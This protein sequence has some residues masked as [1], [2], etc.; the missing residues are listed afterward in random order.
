MDT[1]VAAIVLLADPWVI[2]VILL[3]AALGLFVGA[4]PGLTAAMAVALLVPVTLYM[5]PVPALAMIATLSCMAI[6][7]GDIPGCLLRIPGTLASAAYAEEAYAMT[8]K[9]HA[10]TALGASVVFAAIGG[11]LG[12]VVLVTVAPELAR[13]ALRFSSFEYFWLV[14]LGLSC[15]V[16]VGSQ[17]TTKS[18]LS[19]MLG[20]TV[21]M[22]GLNNPAAFPRLTFG[23]VDLL[24]GVELIAA[25]VGLFA[26]SEIFRMVTSGHRQP[27]PEFRPKG[28][29]LA[30]QW[31]L[32]RRY[33]AQWLGGSGIGTLIGALPG[34]GVDIAAWVSYAVSKRFSRRR[35]LFGTGH[36][37][38]I[39]AAGAANNAAVSGTW[40]P[41]LVFGIPG[42]A[43][44]AILIGVLFL[45]GLSP[46]PMIFQN[47]ADVIVALF[48]VFFAANL[49]MIPFGV[50]AIKLSVHILRIPKLMLVPAIMALCVIGA[51]AITNN[52]VSI[53]VML[54]FGV[55]GFV[56]M[57]NEFPVAPAIL[58]IVLGPMLEQ[59][60][61]NSMIKAD[62]NFL[63]FFARPMA[64]GLGIA[65]I[66]IWAMLAI[67]V[68]AARLR[69]VPS[70]T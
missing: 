46:G 12:T 3:S 50:A 63:E 2:T 58:G 42:D 28:R 5:D 68:A 66:A 21:G 32:L 11:I 17:S 6:F 16:L 56:L 13:I 54:A 64:M 49:L 23:S 34:A 31:K 20:L 70:G 44:T 65:T 51:Y 35:H 47:Q 9:G 33:P 10:E 40:I 57:E 26:V 38:G 14:C 27:A 52:P 7:A 22:I 1:L 59:N 15:A 29:I 41:A 67:G 69:P 37:E 61:F 18:L 24:G 8:Q 4:M 43:I 36:A 45:K 62:G 19:L 60:F 55:A 25:M 48:V 53:L 30:G 39:V